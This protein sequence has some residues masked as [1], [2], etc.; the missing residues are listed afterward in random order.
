MTNLPD[1]LKSQLAKMA[2]GDISDSTTHRLM[3]L[4][5]QLL[6]ER[7]E[8]HRYPIT[9]MFCDWSLH[10][11][12]DRSKPASTLLDLLDGTW[13]TGNADQAIQNIGEGLNPRKLRDE[14]VQLLGSAFIH[15][16]IILD[17]GGFAT[18]MDHLLAELA[19]KPITRRPQ[20]VQNHTSKR[21]AQGQ[22]FMAVQLFFSL[23]EDKKNTP[24]K[25]LLNLMSEQIQPTP[26]G[27]VNVVLPWPLAADTAG[28]VL[29]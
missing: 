26:G 13:S 23:N 15:P 11:K 7:N 6:E 22:R 14:I 17:D 12:L 16:G 29:F 18:I 24:A 21:L 9:A 10:V 27:H 28:N 8:K 3:A 19:D 5:R 2:A 25:Y 1:R 20:D 4:L